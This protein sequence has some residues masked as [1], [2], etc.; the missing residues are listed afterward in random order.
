M[1]GNM[2]LFA[3]ILVTMQLLGGFI[4]MKLMMT[5]W[6]LKRYTKKVMEVSNDIAEELMRDEDSEEE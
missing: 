5:K 4:A 1:L 2:I 6:F 3:F